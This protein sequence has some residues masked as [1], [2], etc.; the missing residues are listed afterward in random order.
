LGWRGV[1]IEKQM[2]EQFG[3]PVVVTSAASAIV[4]SEVQSRDDLDTR[5][6]MA[7]FADDSIG[8]AIANDAAVHPLAVDREDLTTQGLIDT[9]ASPGVGTLHD[10]VATAARNPHTREVL[11]A[12][13]HDL[14]VLAAQLIASHSPDTVVVAGS[15]FIDD[16]AAP[17]VFARAVRS[18]L[19]AQTP[20]Q[21]KV[22][23]RM[24]PTHREVVRDIARAVALDLVL[25]EP[26]AV[27][28]A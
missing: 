28:S 5:R 20:A 10:A 11:N 27:A 13:A 26:L 2:R 17:A 6:V 1:D 19:P 21:T 24:I 14:G 25:R 4:G 23:L 9:L 3:V 16:P 7:L 18:L 8:C 12:R 15:A 22:E